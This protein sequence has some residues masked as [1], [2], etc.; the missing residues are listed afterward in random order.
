M[1]RTLRF[2]VTS[3]IFTSFPVAAQ[4]V[5]TSYDH[6]YDF[7]KVK[8][9]AVKVTPAWSD[10]ALE[11]CARGAVARELEAK[12]WT[13]APDESSADVL[14]VIKGT[15]ENR[16]IEEGYYDGGI[17]G[18]AGVSGPAG[19]TN[20]REIERRLGE[21][22]IDIFD[23]KTND[24]VFSGAGVSEVSDQEWKNKD[25]IVKGVE[26]IFKNFPPKAP[27]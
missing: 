8:T 5:S 21:G 6:K 11:S 7:S 18:P 15:V 12:G 1:K 26:K 25:R 2:L 17:Q 24:L 27:G 22:T 3:V 23:T 4:Q 19:V 13:S 20:A 14:V 9:F 10:S 16:K